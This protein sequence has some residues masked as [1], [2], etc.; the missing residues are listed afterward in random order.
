MYILVCIYLQPSEFVEMQLRKWYVSTHFRD[1]GK[2]KPK[3]PAQHRNCL[4]SKG[5]NTQY[6]RS[7]VPKY[8]ALNGFWD[9]NSESI[10]Y[11]DPLGM[12]YIILSELFLGP[13]PCKH[14]QGF[15]VSNEYSQNRIKMAFKL[16]VPRT[17]RW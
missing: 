14:R 6:L 9:Q 17:Q 4:F 15:A 2:E 16:H 13:P 1:P 11:F 10:R 3:F 7:L 8:H 5:S 12:G